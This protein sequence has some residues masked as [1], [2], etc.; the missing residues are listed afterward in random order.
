MQVVDSL[1]GAVQ[2][3]RLGNILNGHFSW[4]LFFS[5]WEQPLTTL[6]GVSSPLDSLPVPRANNLKRA[7]PILGLCHGVIADQFIFRYI[8]EH[9]S[10]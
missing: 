2:Y 7:N 1:R 8:L 10:P 6:G 9:F 3:Q 5:H 4:F